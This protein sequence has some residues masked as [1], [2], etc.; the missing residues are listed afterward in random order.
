VT[1]K[2]I[3]RY[4]GPAIKRIFQF[5]KQVPNA[6]IPIIR[7]NPLY[8]D[9]LKRGLET[10]DAWHVFVAAKNGCQAFLACDRL[11]RHY[12]AAI[13]QMCGLVVQKPSN[14]VASEGW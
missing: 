10:I 6:C 2:E 12:G 1:L 13:R 7:D 4:Q 14:F 3:D 8:D 5:L 9:L 11:I